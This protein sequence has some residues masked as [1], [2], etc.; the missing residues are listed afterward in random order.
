MFNPTILRANSYNYQSSTINQGQYGAIAPGPRLVSKNNKP[1][2]RKSVKQ[3]GKPVIK[4]ASLPST[5]SSSDFITKLSANLAQI[6]PINRSVYLQIERSIKN[7]GLGAANDWRQKT[8]AIV[9]QWVLPWSKRDRKKLESFLT[10][11]SQL[12]IYTQVYMQRI[13]N[14]KTQLAFDSNMQFSNTETDRTREPAIAA[15]ADE[16]GI[17]KIMSEAALTSGGV[18]VYGSMAVSLFET[19]KI[20]NIDHL[21][22][23]TSLYMLTD[24]WLDD[25]NISK[26]SKIKV[27]A[28][29]AD[30][31]EKP[32]LITTSPVLYILSKN[33]LKL[34]TDIPASHKWLKE[35]YYSE[36]KS[37]II[38]HLPNLSWSVY[39]GLAE[40]KGG[41]MVQCMQAIAGAEPDRYGYMVG[42]CIQLID[43]I[44]D[45]DEDIEEGIE[46]IAIHVNKKYGCLDPL[47]YY[48]VHLIDQFA[49]KHTIF[50]PFLLQMLMHSLAII[51]HFSSK[52]REE[53]KA[54][55]PLDE[56]VSLRGE[57]YEK[58]LQM[59]RGMHD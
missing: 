12:S 48:T 6:E 37:A 57:I 18:A 28:L 7:Q 10:D 47:L 16:M 21:F 38:Q 59:L 30:V 54:Y 9:K 32:R 31:I 11:N 2:S 34:V 52:L 39:L 33:L 56:S 20:C 49:V 5:D 36:M 29:L 45:I 19:Y 51:P 35:A 43:D 22:A 15:K 41:T 55:F 46:T 40:W 58:M 42:A 50:K 4:E 27:G 26:Q 14:I 44:H 17:D 8:I 53:M 25:P 1:I 3:N 13:A 24:T 23:F